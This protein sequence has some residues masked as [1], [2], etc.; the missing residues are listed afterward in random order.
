MRHTSIRRALEALPDKGKSLYAWRNPIGAG[1][2]VDS[3]G[4]PMLSSVYADELVTWM[5]AYRDPAFTWHWVKHLVR[6]RLPF[7]PSIPADREGLFL[8]RLYDHESG[9]LKDWGILQATVFTLPKMHW[10]R[11]VIQA[12]LLAKSDSLQDTC[13]RA[14]VS[15]DVVQTYEKIFYNVFDRAE[16]GLYIAS[17]VYPEGRI[18]EFFDGYARNSDF[19]VLL[20]RAGFR[21]GLDDLLWM[22]GS[23][24]SEK[25]YQR[26]NNDKQIPVKLEAMI[27]TNGYL[28][29]KNGFGFQ[30]GASTP[31]LSG[32]RGMINAA[33]QSG[34]NTGSTDSMA[35][36][37]TAV[38][39]DLY[40]FVNQ[41]AEARN[42]L[43]RQRNIEKAISDAKEA[44]GTILEAVAG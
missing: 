17:L 28:L 14:K 37:G 8:R 18:A 6:N 41:Q 23:R 22:I 24:E 12:L 40:K 13:E 26:Q 25:F 30:S 34:Q 39:A 31:A 36:L 15:L 16:D 29:A 3:D 10:E 2:P 7:P 35:S 33:K 42:I 1:P 44:E 38:S 19:G 27:M 43:V 4:R 11:S 32:A 21:N 20:K 9:K 5:D